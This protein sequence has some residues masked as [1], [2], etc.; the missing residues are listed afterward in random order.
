MICAPVASASWL[1]SS[2]PTTSDSLLASARSIP[3]P[4]AA[5]V[6][7]R[8]AEPTSALRTRSASASTT[9]RT[10]P[11]GPSSTWPSVHASPARA[12]AW[13]SARRDPVDAEGVVAWSTS[14]SQEDWAESPTSSRSSERATMSSACVPID[15]VEPRMSRR[16]GIRWIV[17]SPGFGQLSATP[18][19]RRVTAARSAPASASAGRSARR[20]RRRR[21]CA[22]LAAPQLRGGTRP[23]RQPHRRLTL[24]GDEEAAGLRDAAERDRAPPHR[25]VSA[26]R[27]PVP[28][29]PRWRRSRSS[30]A[31]SPPQRP[32]RRRRRASAARRRVAG[33]RR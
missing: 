2:P 17:G 15:P 22:A 16:R 25:S 24:A 30:A 3:S 12:A 21:A 11:S 33:R 27:A 1:T 5:T 8:P 32:R 18:P 10:R 29:R 26:A 14:V 9:S 13:L 20:S 4:S 28:P 31:P 23:E 19:A 7:P 6:G